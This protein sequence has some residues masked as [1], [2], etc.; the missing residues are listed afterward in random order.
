MYMMLTMMMTMRMNNGIWWWWKL[1]WEAWASYVQHSAPAWAFVGGYLFLPED[2][3]NNDE[4][5]MVNI[6]NDNRLVLV[7]IWDDNG[8]I[9]EHQGAWQ[10]EGKGIRSSCLPKSIKV[11]IFLMM[12]MMMT[13]MMTMTMANAVA[14]TMS[15]KDSKITVQDC[16]CHTG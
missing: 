4:I 12:I 9:S 16:V 3:L 5:M 14:M 11:I 7:N 1:C 6:W 13:K 2:W 15:I 8:D 10:V